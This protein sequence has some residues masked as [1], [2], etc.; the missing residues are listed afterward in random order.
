MRGFTG[1]MSYNSKIMFKVEVERESDGRWIAEVSELPEVMTYGATRREAITRA[2]A[3]S[4][5]VLAEKLEHGEEL[6]QV[7]AVFAIVAA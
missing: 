4:L 5:R 6:P 1:E 3:L 7:E 2:Q